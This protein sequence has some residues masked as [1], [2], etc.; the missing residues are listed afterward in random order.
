[1]KRAVSSPSN[2]N[3]WYDIQRS[4]CTTSFTVAIDRSS[5]VVPWLLTGGGSNLLYEVPFSTWFFLRYHN[6]ETQLFCNPLEAETIDGGLV[7][8]AP[9]ASQ[10]RSELGVDELEMKS[11]KLAGIKCK[12]TKMSRSTKWWCAGYS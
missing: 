12:Q 2:P 5:T 3:S 9:E 10:W 6:N 1:M 7:T 11:Q 4:W 8:V